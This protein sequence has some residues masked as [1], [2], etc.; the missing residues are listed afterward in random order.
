[1]KNTCN[2][3]KEWAS[4][5][6]QAEHRLQHRKSKTLKNRKG[7]RYFSVNALHSIIHDSNAGIYNRAPN[8]ILQI[9]FQKKKKKKFL[10]ITISLPLSIHVRRQRLLHDAAHVRD[11]EKPV[12]LPRQQLDP[13]A[14]VVRAV[15][16]TVRVRHRLTEKSKGRWQR[17]KWNKGMRSGIDRDW[18]K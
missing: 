18:N 8:R 3:H 1:M 13:L 12:L 4:R 16:V 7:C 2:Q 9:K 14:T 15:R 10:Q 17:W 5:T 6:P 11:R